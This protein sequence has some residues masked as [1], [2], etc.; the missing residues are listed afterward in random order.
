MAR[1]MLAGC[2]RGRESLGRPG[3]LPAAGR[4]TWFDSYRK[5]YVE[6]DLGELSQLTRLISATADRVSLWYFRTRAGCG[7]DF[8]LERAGE[9]M[10]IEVKWTSS[11]ASKHRAGLDAARELLGSRWRLAGIPAPGPFMLD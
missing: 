11:V 8:L 4:R 2:T 9:V 3:R 10:G 6:R 5:T 7:V 1:A